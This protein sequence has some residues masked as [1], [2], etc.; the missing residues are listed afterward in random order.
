MT[1][2][3]SSSS[4]QYLLRQATKLPHH[5]LDHHPV[6]APLVRPDLTLVQYGNALEALH[7][8]QVHAEACILAF[9]EH[10]PGLFDYQSRLKLGA[11]ESDLAALGRIP[12]RL[13]TKFPVPET[14]GGLVGVLYTVEGST[15]GG[16][17]IARTLRELPLEDLP[18]QFFTGYGDMSQ[19]RWDEFLQFAE[20]HCPEEEREV[21]VAT[22]VLLFDAIKCHLDVYLSHL[23]PH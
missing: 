18:V 8:V 10:H 22:A 16:Q 3:L 21:A 7:G 23:E 15:Q 11:I 19:Q 4:L 20:T 12:I 2:T 14:I 9:L 6:L 5:A 13:N 17:V 1:N